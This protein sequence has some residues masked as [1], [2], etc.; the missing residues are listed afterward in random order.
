M[1]KNTV[2]SHEGWPALAA[3][4]AQPIIRKA[5]LAS[6]VALALLGVSLDAQALALGAISVRSALGEP[7]RAEIEIPQ[8]SSEEAS[9]LQASM[10][11]PQAFRAAG[12]NYS[13]A[14]AGTHVT[15]QPTARPTCAS[16]ATGRSTNP[17]WVS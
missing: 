3:T 1:H 15:L 4:A 6:A 8:L 10:G 5:A 9:T 14:L 17:T 7:L 11:T 16:S 13:P 2:Q 12:I